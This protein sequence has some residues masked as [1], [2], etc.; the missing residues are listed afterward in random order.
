MVVVVG[1]G[2]VDGDVVVFW[3]GGV[4]AGRCLLLLLFWEK[5]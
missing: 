2:G 5:R 1:A 4:V 3:R